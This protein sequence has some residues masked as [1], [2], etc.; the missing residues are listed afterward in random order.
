M[1]GAKRASLTGY[2]GHSRD[3]PGWLC[4]L[5]PQIVTLTGV[6]I[7]QM[8]LPVYGERGYSDGSSSVYDAAVAFCP[9]N[10]IPGCRF[11]PPVPLGCLP[12]VNSSPNLRSPSPIFTLQL[13]ATVHSVDSHYCPGYISKAMAWIICVI[14]TPFRLSK[15]SC[16]RELKHVFLL[17][18]AIVLD[19]GISLLPQFPYS[20]GAGQILLALLPPPS[21]FFHP[22][23]LCMDLLY[24]PFW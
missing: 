18:Q 8:P 19:A 21:P 1:A 17:S 24:I 6:F 10:G 12:I 22:T 4:T 13:P 2:S 3:D 15:I 5:G 23:K 11:P 20:L 9:S 14:L 7:G 16:L